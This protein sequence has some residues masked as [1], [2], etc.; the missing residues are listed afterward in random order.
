MAGFFPPPG[1]N[2]KITSL[3][4]V[5]QDYLAIWAYIAHWNATGVCFKVKWLENH[6]PQILSVEICIHTRHCQRTGAL[7]NYCWLSLLILLLTDGL[8]K[9]C[10]SPWGLSQAAG[11]W[12][13]VQGR[14]EVSVSWCLLKQP[15]TMIQWKML[16]KYP[17]PHLW[18]I[19][20][21]LPRVPRG[22]GPSCP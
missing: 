3:H 15:S 8:L 11:A 5:L 6:G 9:S 19:L 21:S 1:F 16:D 18:G 12:S 7:P 20:C 2:F 22:M 14:L 17:N 13:I 4:K 10:D